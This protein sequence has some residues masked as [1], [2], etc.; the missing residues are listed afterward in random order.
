MCLKIMHANYCFSLYRICG[1]VVSLQHVAV[2]ATVAASAAIRVARATTRELTTRMSCTFEKLLQS[3]S[4]SRPA[5]C[6]QCSG[7][8]GEKR[9]ASD[10]P[11]AGGAGI[12]TGGRTT[13]R[14]KKNAKR[15][16]KTQLRV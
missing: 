14:V 11:R 5:P 2:S 12:S 4:P 13:L 15:V 16:K 6:V 7:V 8:D 10:K 9:K 1:R 3:T